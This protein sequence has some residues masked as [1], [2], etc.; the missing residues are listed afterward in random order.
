MTVQGA[1]HE[2]VRGSA[3][4]HAG[5]RFAS[6]PS[7]LTR[8]ISPGFRTIVRRIDTGLERGSLLA[9]LPDGTTEMLGGRSPGFDAEIWLKDWRALLRL[10]AS[11]VI[12]FYQGYEAGEW[13]TPDMV[14]LLA[15]MSANVRTLGDAA[16]STGPFKWAAKLAHRLNRNSKV[17]SLRNIAAHYDIGNDFYRA[18]L[19]P[20]MAYSSAFSIG[21]DGLEAAQ[22]RKFSALSERLAD[23][24]SALEIGCG[25]G[26]LADH[27]AK[28]GAHVTA[29]SL[30]D[31]QLGYA[32][33]SASEN[34]DFLKLDYRDVTS[35]YDA[36]VSC[37]MV[38]ALGREY[39]PDFMDCVA[40]SL[41]PG[42]RAAIQYI[43]IADDLYDAY[44]QTV[45]FIQAY[46]FPGG[47]LIRTSEFRALAEERGLEWRDQVDFGLDY[48]E[49][50]RLWHANFDAAVHEKRLPAGFD[51]R[52]VRLW[53]FY[54][55]YCEA[56]FRA[57]N[58]DVHQVTLIKA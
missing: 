11:G 6:A 29:I 14:A 26:S 31:E 9:H 3:L 20:T 53:K 35:Q 24:D 44:A 57:G 13:E 32:R 5:E 38:E 55:T 48:A 47:M 58:I 49:T 28:G 19:D 1:T 16:R 41:K 50:L 10:A 40:R 22:R 18:W 23:P 36:I 45:D 7:L 33:A 37:E 12:G 2:E 43:S 56:G 4:L 52:F 17:G 15:L 42:G 34:V 8:L 25:W 30:S 46:I 27:L 21:S 54:L 39:W 51:H